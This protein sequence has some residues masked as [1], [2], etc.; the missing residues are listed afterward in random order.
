MI[1]R[2]IISQEVRNVAALRK[3]VRRILSAQRD[4][5]APQAIENVK[6][7]LADLTDALNSGAKGEAL[8]KAMGRVEEAANK[9]LKP[10]PHAG[11]RENVEVLLVALAVAMAIRTFFIQ[12]FKI[13]T[14]SM[15]PTLFG[16]TSENLRDKPDFKIPTGWER[17]KEWFAGV[18]YVHV[19]AQ[20]DG[21]LQPVEPE[22][23]L[24]NGQGP[25]E[26]V[27][28][29]VRFLIFNIKQSFSIGGVEHTMWFPPDLG[30]A[31]LEYR[32]GLEAG[33]SYRKGDDVV[34]IRVSA[35]DHLF[36]D[37]LTYNFRKPTRGEIIVFET[38][39]I[40]NP[41]QFGVNQMP[42]DEF[43]IKRLVVLPGD[44]VQIGDDRHLV[45]NGQRLDASTPHFENV[46]GFNPSTPPR[47]SQFSGHVNGTVAQEFNLYPNLAPLF[48]NAQTIFT[49]GD[50][51]YMVMGDNTCNSSDSRT[52]GSFPSKN[53]IGKS[54]FVYW[55]IT[56]R[57]GWGNQ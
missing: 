34:K 18:S 52:W 53:V 28:P 17:V 24:N 19:V 14:G 30:E 12:P 16:V 4:I 57:F 21:E 6:R 47:E 29:P 45:I 50:D 31:P 27:E 46:Y 11:W 32:A 5:L 33:R 44:R 1:L 39:G 20:T 26:V 54:F 43:Y 23:R 40:N 9:W 56:G 38:R 13:P 48:P 51:S 10:Y 15:Q 41:D 37:R 36:V 2:W 25:L 35:G 3:H 7:A 55:P 22:T 42:Q 8:K 49:N